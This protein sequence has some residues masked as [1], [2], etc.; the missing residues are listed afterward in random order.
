MKL[1][2]FNFS[3]KFETDKYISG[4][5]VDLQKFSIQLIL[6]KIID[7]FARNQEEVRTRYMGSI[8][9]YLE[10]LKHEI[11]I[12][13]YVSPYGKTSEYTFKPIDVSLTALNTIEKM[14]IVK[15]SNAKSV[16]FDNGYFLTNV[17]CKIQT[18]AS[19]TLGIEF[20]FI[21][22]SWDGLK[23]VYETVIIIDD[24]SSYSGFPTI[25]YQTSCGKDQYLQSAH[26]SS[27]GNI[28][29]GNIPVVK[30]DAKCVKPRPDW[31]YA[32]IAKTQY[33]TGIDNN[34]LYAILFIVVVYIL[35]S[36]QTQ[37]QQGAQKRTDRDGQQPEV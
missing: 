26:L 22:Q 12:G 37:T 16:K 35:Y 36:R 1:F 14:E 20:K 9:Q 10:M 32:P 5:V 11:V 8:N 17:K 15:S 19:N 2:D 4:V 31:E 33:I 7:L 21:T 27:S 3:S 23:K 30:F 6:D 25:S 24:N 13:H 34:I 18:Q 28:I 29:S